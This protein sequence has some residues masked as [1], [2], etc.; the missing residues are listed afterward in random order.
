M[1]EQFIKDWF[2]KTPEFDNV[3]RFILDS[4]VQIVPEEGL[5]WMPGYTN[6][7]VCKKPHHT[8][9]YIR[10]MEESMFMLHDVIHQIW[11][12][13]IQ[14]D[15]TEYEYVI[16]Q[17]HGELITFYLVEYYIPKAWYETH[18]KYIDDIRGSY[19]MMYEILQQRPD[20]INV[21]DWMYSIFIHG[22]YIDIPQKEALEKYR[23]M[24]KEDKL[25][26]MQN[27][28]L[29]KDLEDKPNYCIS[30]MNGQNHVDFFKAVCS[31]AVVNI[32]REFNFFNLVIVF[33]TESK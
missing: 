11:T 26:S 21:V 28:R 7:S 25:A 4:G 10:F 32:K 20:N 23:K 5:K 16:R 9:P 13:N 33:V 3:A 24:F 30:G 1:I 31:G 22:K 2:P 14:K 12:M 8:D 27:Y 19:W 6:I 15:V 17:L 18:S 29:I